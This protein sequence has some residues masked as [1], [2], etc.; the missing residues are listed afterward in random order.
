MSN[1]K[2]SRK[3][4]QQPIVLVNN[5][6]STLHPAS[7]SKHTNKKTK[8]SSEPYTLQKP[9]QPTLTEID[10]NIVKD[11]YALPPGTGDIAVNSLPSDVS[12]INPQQQSTA[13]DASLGLRSVP[14]DF[15]FG[16]NRTELNRLEPYASYSTVQSSGSAP[17]DMEMDQPVNPAST[18]QK[19]IPIVP[20]DPIPVLPNLVIATP[21]DTVKGKSASDKKT[22]I[23]RFFGTNGIATA[24]VRNVA[25]KSYICV[26]F[27]VQSDA[28]DALKRDTAL[29][30]NSQKE[31]ASAPTFTL[32]TTIKS[33]KTEDEKIAARTCTIQVIDIPLYR[34]GADIRAAFSNFSTIIKLSMVTKGLYQNAYIQFDSTVAS[35]YFTDNAWNAKNYRTFNYAYVNFL[36]EED[37]VKAAQTHYSYKGKPLHWTSPDAQ[38]CN[39]CGNPD[40]LAKSCN[41]RSQQINRNKKYKNIYNRFKPAQYR[42]NR[43]QNK[44]K[45]FADVVKGKNQGHPK[46]NNGNNCTPNPNFQNDTANGGSIHDNQLVDAQLHQVRQ[47]MTELQSMFKGLQAEVT[48]L[49][50]KVDDRI[51]NKS[52]SHSPVLQKPT[53]TIPTPIILQKQKQIAPVPQTPISKIEQSFSTKQT[54]RTQRESN[55]LYKNDNRYQAFFTAP[56]GDQAKGSGTGIIISAKYARFIQDHKGF[57]GRIMKVDFFMCSNIKLRV[58]QVYGYPGSDRKDITELWDHVIQLIKDAQ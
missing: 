5:N 53:P 8:I 32:F 56:F 20:F 33:N 1:S 23:R 30:I 3:T 7:S 48:T 4:A 51:K 47:M 58:I 24:S 25:R 16:K 35:T 40:H 57:K 14:F 54:W 19:M 26:H 28:D 49:N 22:Y 42:G 46:N 9:T 17:T 39:F 43:Q 31:G 29:L 45:F 55:L 12:S 13:A 27:N 41:N 15:G 21:A 52:V 34:K 36:T 2:N 50:R 18:Q 6:N 11:T 38:C 10:E 44:Q 37:M